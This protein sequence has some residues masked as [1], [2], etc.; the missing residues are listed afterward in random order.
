MK[1]MILAVAAAFAVAAASAAI[2]STN[3]FETS[4]GDFSTESGYTLSDLVGLVDY[5]SDQP[6][7]SA[8]APFSDFGAKYM[9]LCT[10]DAMVWR[11]FTTQSA[12]VY[13]DSYVK[14]SPCDDD[15]A[16]TSDAKFVVFVDAGNHLCVISGT[17]DDDQTPVTNVLVTTSQITAD[18][19]H[20]LTVCAKSGSVYA[21]SI[22]L[23]GNPSALVAASGSPSEGDSTFYSL[24]NGETMSE[25]GM[26]GVGAIDD[27][28]VRTTAPVL[29]G[30]VAATIDGEDFA[31][32]EAALAAANGSQVTLTA[33]H[34]APVEV[35]VAGTYVVDAGSYAFGGFC[36]KNGVAVGSSTIG[37]V[38]TCAATAPVA[39]WDGAIAEYNFS[40]LTRT[41]GTVTY[42]LQSNS[43]HDTVTSSYIEL[44]SANQ[45]AAP[46]ITASAG[47][48][49]PFGNGN[50]TVIMKCANMPVAYNGSNRAII[51]LYNDSNTAMIGIKM[52]YRDGGFI[53]NGKEYTVGG[54]QKSVFSAN[55]QVV[56]MTYS[57][58]DGTSYF[59]NGELAATASAL[60]FSNFKSPAGISLGGLPVPE[61]TEFHELRNMKIRAVAVFSTKLTDAQIANYAFPSE[62]HIVVESDSTVAVS[63]INSAATASELYL[64]ILQGA[65]VTVDED[66]AASVVRPIDEG[67]IVYSGRVPQAGVLNFNALAWK[68]TVEI[69]NL[70]PASTDV[71]EPTYPI[72]LQN[73]GN[74]NSSI[75]LASIGAEVLKTVY[76]RGAVTN[77]SKV[78]LVDAGGT[79]A[80]RLSDGI[81]NVCTTFREIAGTG[82]FTNINAN[83]K[84]GITVNVMT[85]FTGN[86]APKYLTVTFG[87]AARKG[88]K[89]DA[90]GNWITDNTTVDRIFIDP[91]A[92]LS[93]PAGFQLWA[94][95]AVEFNGPVNFTTSTTNYDG[96]ELFT[97]VGGTVNFGASAAFTINGQAVGG[98]KMMKVGNK[99]VLKKKGAIIHIF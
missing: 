96:L 50:C 70:Q 67:K 73:Y 88:Q 91:D 84:Q 68:G 77:E 34:S 31:T 4:Y 40:T 82:A 17:A 56:A 60:K 61:S 54:T 51:T 22:Y 57:T 25:V 59:V 10:G 37:T 33:N 23:D 8:P 30:S 99:I 6:L 62:Q 53:S 12:D 52:K 89:L 65:T 11:S 18:S 64:H 38:T 21:F 71:R 83:I 94:P 3:N 1:R 98:Y 92:V 74:A 79:P 2:V 48:S 58:G 45:E 43:A 29:G 90:Q 97:N 85:N 69:S 5:D 35:S 16:Y 13:F 49:Y 87:A 72:E 81:S 9:S 44:P 46:T 93:V 7:A 76:M 86:F 36:G 19:W 41:S 78:V 26:K 80:L 20:R 42:T 15:F 28:V 75:R 32:L 55:D 47:A 63:Q 27:L 24:T 39:L 66:F 95:T 14:M